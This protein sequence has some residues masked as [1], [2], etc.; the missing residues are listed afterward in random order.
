[1]TDPRPNSDNIARAVREAFGH[2]RVL[3]VGDLMLDR[4]LAGK[5][6]RISPEAPVPV[7]NP[8]SE[9]VRAGGAGTPWSGPR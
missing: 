1:M 6:E 7:L 2:R 9:D 8:E 4:Y 3:V 5:V